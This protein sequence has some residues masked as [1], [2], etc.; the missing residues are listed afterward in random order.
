[1]N[2]RQRM[3]LAL[4][5]K[6]LGY[7]R[8]LKSISREE[9]AQAAFES[10]GQDYN[11]LVRLTAEYFPELAELLPP[12]VHFQGGKSEGYRYSHETRTDIY[13]FSEAVF[14]LLSSVDDD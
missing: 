4:M 3:R 13:V 12:E 9:R 14:Q 11:T 10:L 7:V 2:Q 5:S 8:S 1:M 6:A